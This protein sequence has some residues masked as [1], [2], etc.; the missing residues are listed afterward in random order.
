MDLILGKYI[1]KY[2]KTQNKSGSHGHFLEAR[3]SL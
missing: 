1:I 3:P 2:E